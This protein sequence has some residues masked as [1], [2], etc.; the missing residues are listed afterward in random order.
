MI[1]VPDM[2]NMPKP[3]P[4]PPVERPLTPSSPVSSGSGDMKLHLPTSEGVPGEGRFVRG[5]TPL[6]W[7]KRV[8]EEVED[9]H[10]SI[11]CK[12]ISEDQVWL[13]EQSVCVV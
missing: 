7:S 2:D 4:P 8:L 10:L 13:F 3:P 12:F 1:Y 5:V 11:V 9:T 6:N